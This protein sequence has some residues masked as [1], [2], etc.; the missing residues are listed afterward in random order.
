MITCRLITGTIVFIASTPVVLVTLR[1]CS[2]D[3]NAVL[4]AVLFSLKGHRLFWLVACATVSI[5]LDRLVGKPNRQPLLFSCFLV[6]GSRL[7]SPL[8]GRVEIINHQKKLT[9]LSISPDQPNQLMR[10]HSTHQL[11]SHTNGYHCCLSFIVP[12]ITSLDVKL[13]IVRGQIT[14]QSQPI[15]HHM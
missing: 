3:D 5:G 15:A 8:T 9:G 7:S 6:E 14:T 13:C 1:I 11:T 2:R 10:W 4:T 12:F